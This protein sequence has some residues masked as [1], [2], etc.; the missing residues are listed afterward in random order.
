MH[1][2]SSIFWVRIYNIWSEKPGSHFSDKFP[3][4]ARAGWINA[5]RALAKHRPGSDDTSLQLATFRIM[6]TVKLSTELL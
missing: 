5:W 3:E 4:W 2:H 6:R 1:K